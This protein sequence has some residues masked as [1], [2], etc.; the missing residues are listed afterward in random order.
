MV[1]TGPTRG[2]HRTPIV[3]CQSVVRSSPFSS[4]DLVLAM[5][6]NSVA[7]AIP[8]AQV[9]KPANR[10]TRLAQSQALRQ[11]QWWAWFPARRFRQRYGSTPPP[12]RAQALT[13]RDQCGSAEVARPHLRSAGRPRAGRRLLRCHRPGMQGTARGRMQRAR[14]YPVGERGP[15]CAL[16]GRS[17]SHLKALR[18]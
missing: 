16:A 13:A 15:L 18:P 12:W 6:P 5:Q 3:L 7:Q 8:S 9:R 10:E 14:P 1:S 2:Q 17:C 4:R 11:S